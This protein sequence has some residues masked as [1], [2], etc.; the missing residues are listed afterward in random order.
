MT[1]DE[2]RRTKDEGRRMKDEGRRT[3]DE[4]RTKTGRCCGLGAVWCS[5][6]ALRR[7]CG[8]D[9]PHAKSFSELTHQLRE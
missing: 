8:A 5:A 9:S 1:K 3:K 4:G 2:G 7:Q 6:A